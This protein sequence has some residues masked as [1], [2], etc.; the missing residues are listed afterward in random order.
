MRRIVFG[1]LFA[2]VFSVNAAFAADNSAGAK[3]YV[4]NVAKQAV[5]IIA[6][7]REGT[8]TADQ[9]KQNFRK[10]LNS[11][12]DIP[13]IAKFTL[14]RYWRVATPA[15]QTEYTQLLQTTILDKY[16]DNMLESA[17]EKYTLN[18]ARAINDRDYSVDMTGYSKEGQSVAF[19]WRLRE[20]NGA[21]KVIDIAVEGVSMSVTHR[22]DFAS[23]IER[24]GGQ[25][26]SLLDALKNKEFSKK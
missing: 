1:V 21:F 8:L 18:A 11:S 16:A 19:G 5:G 13:T 26:Q 23:V 17:G 10:I 24:N 20:A 3:A 22:S 15:Q 2:M 9:A 4:D 6:Q 7:T 14:G 12:F 25:V